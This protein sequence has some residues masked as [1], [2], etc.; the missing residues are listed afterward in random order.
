MFLGHIALMCLL[1]SSCTAVLN[2]LFFVV[3]A[4][5]VCVCDP[6]VLSR[7]PT[8][9]LHM[10]NTAALMLML[11]TLLYERWLERHKERDC[12]RLFFYFRFVLWEIRKIQNLSGIRT[13]M[14]K[15]YRGLCKDAHLRV[16]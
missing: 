10:N 12:S 11:I 5:C 13:L 1:F 8:V 15:P 16:W 7:F 14:I 3:V 6:A 9:N 4:A 2:E